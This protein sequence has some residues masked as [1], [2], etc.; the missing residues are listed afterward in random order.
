MKFP[1]LVLISGSDKF[2]IWSKLVIIIMFFFMF[3]MLNLRLP[4]MSYSKRAGLQTYGGG[5]NAENYCTRR[6]FACMVRL[7]T[8]K[9][10]Q[11]QICFFQRQHINLM[12]W[13]FARIAGNGASEKNLKE[14]VCAQFE[15]NFAK[16][17]WRV[18]GLYYHTRQSCTTCQKPLMIVLITLLKN[19]TINSTAVR[20][21]CCIANHGMIP[22]FSECITVLS[23]ND[24]GLSF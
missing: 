22:R 9:Q 10:T 8:N 19:S 14:G 24:S 20:V 12:F 5:P 18:R 4:L 3:L 15:K 2:L 11:T 13:I 21:N 1:L 7:Y 17:K 6:T 16:A 23:G